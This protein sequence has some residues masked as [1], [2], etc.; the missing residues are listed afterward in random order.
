MSKESDITLEGF[1]SD[2]ATKW[3]I[4]VYIYK[5]INPCLIGEQ[6][7]GETRGIYY[8]WTR[9]EDTNQQKAPNVEPGESWQTAGIMNHLSKQKEEKKKK[10]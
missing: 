5:Y 8:T 6:H 9:T 7:E 2:T 10:K 1:A 3:H 4:Q